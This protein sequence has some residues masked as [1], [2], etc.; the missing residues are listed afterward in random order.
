MA[1]QYWLNGKWSFPRLP[2]RT[3]Q[4]IL[5]EYP[6][7]GIVR[8]S[9]QNPAHT[10]RACYVKALFPPPAS[11]KSQMLSWGQV[12][13]GRKLKELESIPKQQVKSEDVVE[14]IEWHQMKERG[15]SKQ[16]HRIKQ[17]A[18]LTVL[19]GGDCVTL[20]RL[21]ELCLPDSRSCLRRLPSWAQGPQSCHI[22][23]HPS[24]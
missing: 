17:L 21:Q 14:I 19:E 22:N 10:R 23:V 2:A 15:R 16:L 11:L 9:R 3:S 20:S 12:E 13:G 24:W 1:T 5:L 18:F 7:M 6:G 4:Q 8:F